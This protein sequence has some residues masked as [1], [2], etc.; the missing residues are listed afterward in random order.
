ML[1]EFNA[2][3]WKINEIVKILL[4]IE[5]KLSN[6]PLTATRAFPSS[7]STSIENKH[8]EIE[9]VKV[10]EKSSFKDGDV[11]EMHIL[12]KGNTIIVYNVIHLNQYYLTDNMGEKTFFN[13]FDHCIKYIKE[14]MI[15]T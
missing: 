8:E 3:Y 4:R 6:N 10:I 2:W 15:F 14:K 9:I 5:A 7:V 12:Y 13:N 11:K 1:R